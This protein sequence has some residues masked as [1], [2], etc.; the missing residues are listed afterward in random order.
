MIDA[1]KGLRNFLMA[2]QV[3]DVHK[4]KPIRIL[5][6]E[7]DDADA[8]LIREY[9][10]EG[11]K[12]PHVL[13][14]ADRLS[15]GFECLDRDEFDV[16]LLDLGLPDTNGYD[17]F[18]KAHAQVHPVPI[19]VLTGRDD[20]EYAM[21]AV[22]KGAQDYLVK[23]QVNGILL[24]RAI[25][26]AI[27]RQKLRI[28]LETSSREIKIL[29]GLLPI[30]A[31]CKKIRDDQGY[32]TQMEVYISKHSEAEFTHGYCPACAQNFYE[33]FERTT[34]KPSPE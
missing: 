29:R 23:G 31:S 26:Y 3:N 30:C 14:H 27:E 9:L 1:V 25:R 19:V 16:I 4:F 32:W 15:R 7:D 5:L 33:E 17:G 34:K 2:R 12:V 10:S 13:E 11:M 24:A 18:V 22:Q 8:F 28:Q 6:I 21:E 20:D